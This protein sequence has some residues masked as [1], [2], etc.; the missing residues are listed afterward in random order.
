MFISCVFFEDNFPF[1]N[2]SEE[3]DVDSLFSDVVLPCSASGFVPQQSTSFVP[4]DI[5]AHA[6]DIDT[7]VAIDTHTTDVSSTFNNFATQLN[8][9]ASL[10]EKSTTTIGSSLRRSA[11]PHQHPCFL[12]D[13]HCNLLLHQP[14]LNSLVPHSIHTCDSSPGC[15]SLCVICL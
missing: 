4:L 3:S 1:H 6:E 9:N 13:Y 7:F 12:Q 10:V 11:R 14:P 5:D 15:Q 2:I 8:S